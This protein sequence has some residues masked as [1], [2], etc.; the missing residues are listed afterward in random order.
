[1]YVRGLSLQPEE[2]EQCPVYTAG[3]TDW[4][5]VRSETE[6]ELQ[7]LHRKEGPGG[8]GWVTVSFSSLY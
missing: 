8:A 1:M 4:A 5:V 2:E 6:G 3:E 7:G